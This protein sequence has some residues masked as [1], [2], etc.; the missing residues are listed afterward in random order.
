MIIRIAFL[1]VIF[2]CNSASAEQVTY[3]IEGDLLPVH[4][5]MPY[6][7]DNSSFLWELTIDT[8][9]G[10]LGGSNDD[11]AHWNQAASVITISNRDGLPSITSTVSDDDPYKLSLYKDDVDLGIDYMYF[12][13][14]AIDSFNDGWPIGSIR[15]QIN[16]FV[17]RLGASYFEDGEIPALP[18][19]FEGVVPDHDEAWGGN[20]FAYIVGGGGQA[21]VVPS[22]VTISVVPIPNTTI[23]AAINIYNSVLHPKHDGSGSNQDDVIPVIVHGSSTLVGDLADLDTDDIDV[24]T[25]RFGPGM[26]S[27]SPT[28]QSWFNFDLDSDGLD[29]AI[30]QFQMSDAAFDKVTCSDNT[31]TLVGELTTGETFTGD[32][33]FI[34]NCNAGCH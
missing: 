2:A 33:S 1:S 15:V 10:Y 14:G 7:L 25:L 9:L 19:N 13:G 18:T 12:R 17:F 6:G 31:G 4:D 23:P 22:N 21:W 26:G 24:E 28:G 27:I 11:Q 32:D 30:F 16:G 29:D 8:E 34:S 5:N 20:Y 3:R